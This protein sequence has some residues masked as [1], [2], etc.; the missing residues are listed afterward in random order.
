MKYRVDAN[1]TLYLKQI[2]FYLDNFTQHV[3]YSRHVIK[4]VL[5]LKDLELKVVYF[6]D[7]DHS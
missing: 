1:V 2:H 5:D 6:V 3:T 7:M 4:L